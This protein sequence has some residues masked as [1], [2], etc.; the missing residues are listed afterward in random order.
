MSATAYREWPA[1]TAE[2][3][4]IKIT[5]AHGVELTDKGVAAVLDGYAID[6]LT[7]SRTYATFYA[8]AQ[9]RGLTA[10]VPA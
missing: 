4:T 8:E 6:E 5:R 3:F 9:R 10:A 1:P 7:D 2:P